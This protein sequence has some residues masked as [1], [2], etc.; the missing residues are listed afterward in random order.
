MTRER[1]LACDSTA[2]EARQE[3]PRAG[4][5]RRAA[6]RSW[7]GRSGALFGQSRDCDLVDVLEGETSHGGEQVGEV[8]GSGHE[9]VDDVQ[10]GKEI[11][12]EEEG[13]AGEVAVQED[14]VAFGV[15]IVTESV[16][17]AAAG[18]GENGGDELGGFNSLEDGG[19]GAPLLQALALPQDGPVAARV[20]FEVPG[21][22]DVG[23]SGGRRLVALGKVRNSGAKT[24]VG[25]EEGRDGRV[26]RSCSVS[27]GLGLLCALC[28]GPGDDKRQRRIRNEDAASRLGPGRSPRRG[29][30]AAAAGSQGP[31]L[32]HDPGAVAGGDPGVPR[33]AAERG[34]EDFVGVPGRAAQT[35]VAAEGGEAPRRLLFDRD[36]V[37]S[38]ADS[39]DLPQRKIIHRKVSFSTASPPS[40]PQLRTIRRNS[41]FSTA[42]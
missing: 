22:G 10:S 6:V 16:A 3:S 18:T 28:F 34:E 5:L 23:L 9:G 39:R 8:A 27:M 40:S 21:A 37:F 25:R 15:G 30:L 4:R 11:F 29:A 32:R 41:R 38:T 35:G 13:V 31:E 14:L 19:G 12:V 17:K 20:G 24:C 1:N 33:E 42:T 36:V 7:N 2:N 26:L